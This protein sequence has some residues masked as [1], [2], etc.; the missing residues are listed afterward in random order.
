MSNMSSNMTMQDEGTDNGPNPY[1]FNIETAT[2]NNSMFR[3]AVWTGPFLQVTVM[4]LEPGEDIGAEIHENLDQ[5]IRVEQGT[6]M[7]MIGNAKNALTFKA[8]VD[9]SYAIIIPAGTWHNLVNTGDMPL[10][11]YSIYSLPVHP[12]NTVH[13]TK[14]DAIEAEENSMN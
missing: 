4:S 7:A 14:E 13:E 11:V 1:V 8:P 5:F 12:K 6:G 10:K 3:R 2:Q 9:S